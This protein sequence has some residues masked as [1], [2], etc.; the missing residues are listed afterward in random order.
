MTGGRSELSLRRKDEMAGK[1]EV[2]LIAEVGSLLQHTAINI[3]V[4]Q[5]RTYKSTIYGR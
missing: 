2:D 3:T 1:I 5:R 4:E